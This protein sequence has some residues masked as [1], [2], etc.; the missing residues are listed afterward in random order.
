MFRTY[1]NLAFGAVFGALAAA[2]AAPAFAVELPCRAVRMIVPWNAGGDTDLIF[3]PVAEAVNALAPKAPL[4][5]VNIGGQSGNKGA[6]EARAAKPDGCTLL[7]MHDSQITTFLA[8]GVDFTWDVFQPVALLTYTPSMVAAGTKTPYN[9]LAGLIDYAK[10]NPGQ[11]KAGVT[12]GSTSQFLQLLIED[13]A[14]ISFKYVPYEGTRERN[15]ALLANNIDVGEGNILTAKE[16]VK[17]NQMKALGIATEK[18]DPIMPD[19]K[20]M[21]EQGV[22]V[23]YGL[24]R[25]VVL[26]KG[27]SADLVAYYEDLFRRAMQAPKVKEV[28]DTHST[29]IQFKGAK[30]YAE[31]LKKEYGNSERLAIK[32]GLYK[33]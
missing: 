15:T 24:S 30:D 31:F 27:A 13:A 19:L 1:W 18:R 14:K 25:G 20:T 26:P 29:W 3:R 9:D 21:R 17:N 33:K 2:S 4:Q 6:R 12:T 16:Y 7:A 32:I 8:G 5:V 10:K 23:V 28:M 11:I 22:D